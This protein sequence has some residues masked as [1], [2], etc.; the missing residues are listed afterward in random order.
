MNTQPPKR[1]V[2]GFARLAVTTFY[3]VDRIGGPIPDGPLLLVANHPNTL[4]DPALIQT[5]AG[6]PVRFLTKSTLFRRHPLS[7][8][9]RHSG[10]IPV[11]RTIDPGVDTTRNTE[12]FRAVEATLAQGDAICLFPEGV[13]HD[14]GRLVP[15][16]TGTA[17]MALASHA[18]GVPITIVPVGLNFE[19][20][21]AFR[22]RVTAVFGH[23]FDCADLS[24]A[25]AADGQPGGSRADRSHQRTP[26][27]AGGGGR[28]PARS[29]RRGTHRSVVRRGA[30]CLARS[31][32]TH[33]PAPS[34]RRRPRTAATP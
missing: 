23:P 3:R 13:S 7:V 1:W 2:W 6:R 19:H 31:A 12:M 29:S 30:R 32:R 22:S 16:R 34:H 21:S 11:Y 17:R 33:R 28:A 18:R 25:Y 10:A 15:L 4:L 24:E 27:A 9:V 26:Q 20:V 8:L 5:T 14:R